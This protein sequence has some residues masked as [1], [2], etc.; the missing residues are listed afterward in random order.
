MVFVVSNERSGTVSPLRS[1][2]CSMSI[3]LR[4]GDRECCL[5]APTRRGQLHWLRPQTP[6]HV[7]E[8]D[9]DRNHFCYVHKFVPINVK[10]TEGPAPGLEEGAQRAGQEDQGHR[11]VPE[12]VLEDC[13]PTAGQR[14]PDATPPASFLGMGQDVP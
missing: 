8:E 7:D 5:A 11:A 12:R 13:V 1:S 9:E 2:H 6:G 14:Q 10:G 3:C 4:R